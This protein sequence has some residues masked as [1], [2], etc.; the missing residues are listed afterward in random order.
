VGTASNAFMQQNPE[1]MT[2]WAKA[3]DYA[4]SRT[5]ELSGGMWVRHAIHDTRTQPAA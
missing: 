1:F 2:Q 5:Y 3:E 4:D